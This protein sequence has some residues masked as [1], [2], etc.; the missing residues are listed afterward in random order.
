M[1]ELHTAFHL[2]RLT[3][4]LHYNRSGRNSR[5]FEEYWMDFKHTGTIE[6]MCHQASRKSVHAYITIQVNVTPTFGSDNFRRS[7]M[8]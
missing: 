2:T 3:V 7:T 4:S 1:V 8:V 5:D 6:W